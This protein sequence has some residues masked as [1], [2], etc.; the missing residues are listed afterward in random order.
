VSSKRTKLQ[1]RYE[2]RETLGRGGMGI[3][4]KAYD[5]LMNR[6]VA[7]KTILDVDNPETLAMFYKEW[8]TL[9]A[10]VH[11]NVINIYDI[12]EFEDEGAKKPFFVMPLLPG[13]TLDKLIKEAS[14]RLSVA[15]VLAIIDQAAR[16]LHAA[17]EQGLIHRDVKPSNI[18]VM[19]DGSVKIIDFGIVR[20]ASA[21]S[22]TTLK[23]TLY[24]MAPEQLSMKPPSPLSDMFALGAVTYEALTRLRPFRG[25]NDGEVIEAIQKH[26]PPPISELNHEV[27][28]AISQ[29][30]HKAMAKQPWHRFFNMR[31]YGDALMKALR[32]EPLE[33]FDATKIKPRLERAAQSYEQADYEF[34]SEVL[35]ELEAEGHLD[36]GIALLR[37]QVDQAVRQI[38]IK[39]MLENARRF[40]EANEFPLAL[41]KIQ[42][43][44]DLDA[45]DATALSL[46][47]QVERERREK[48]ISEWIT[49]SRQ[50]LENQAFRQA[51]EALENVLQLKPN[52]TDA[53]SLAAEVGRREKEVAAVREQKAKLYQAAMQAWEQGDVT[54]ALTKLESLLVMD[55]DNPEADTGRSHTY[56]GL[57]NKVHSEHNTL[58]NSLEEAHRHLSG[59]NYEAALAIC[60]QYLVKY[61]NHVL[62]QSLKFDVEERQRQGLSRVIAET[63]KRVEEEPDLD[64]RMAI[65]EEVLKVYPGEPHFM[66][67]I[68]LVRDKRDLVNSIVTKARFFEERGQF[69]E[70]LDQWQILKSI[71]EKQ[72]GLAFEIE[73]VIKRRDTQ[74]L[75]NS[76]ARWVEQTD[77][78]L[79]GG[80]YERARKT[81]QNALLE[82]PNEAELLELDK[83]V[84][85]HQERANQATELLGRAR[86]SGDSWTVDQT[87][88]DLREAYKLDPRNSVIRTVL[89]NTLL[90]HARQSM[91]KNPETAETALNEILQLDPG[92]VPARSQLTQLADHKR[93]EFVAWCLTQ[94]RRLQT[95]GDFAGAL[96]VAGQGLASYPNDPRLLQ[97][98]ATLSRVQDAAQKSQ[99]AARTQNP[100]S[101][102][103][104]PAPV[105]P[106]PPT[107][108]P[109]PPQATVPRAASQPVSQPPA[110]LPAA[111][112]VL[113]PPPPSPQLRMPP[114]PPGWK[115][116]A[117]ESDLTSSEVKVLIPTAARSPSPPPNDQKNGKKKT[118]YA[119][120][121]LG[122]GV[123]VLVLSGVAYL[124]RNKSVPPPPPVEVANIKV[125]L[126][127]TPPGAEISVNG[128]ACTSPCEMEL[129]PGDYKAEAK[130]ANFQ[131]ATV[132]FTIA[133][134][135]TSVPDVNL[136]L[137]PPASLVTITTD[138]PDGTVQLDGA[139]VGQI[140]GTDFEIPKLTPAQHVIYL[141]SGAFSSKVTVD[142]AEGA[143]PKVAGMQ[144]NAMHGFVVSHSGSTAQV[145]GSLD[146]A[147][148]S[149]DGKPVG[150]LN[151]GGL[152]LKDLSPGSHEVLVESQAGSAR[153]TF[154]TGAT[155]LT[156]ALMSQ[157]NI[158]VLYIAA[159]QDGVEIYINGEK[160]K[161]TTIAG[162]VR[163]NLPP[164]SYVVRVQKVGFVTPPEQ[165]ANLPKADAVHLEF[166]LI[167]ARA[168]LMIHHGVVG[169]EVFVD[170]TRIGLVDPSGEFSAAYIEPGR[171]TVSLKHDRLQTR[172]SEQVF[173]VGKT[174][175]LEGALQSLMGTLKIE[176]TPSDARVRVRKLGEQQDQD[177]RD[178][179]IS[180]AEGM[181]TVSAS[182]P[183]YQDAQTTVRVPAG[184]F[185]TAQLPLRRVESNAPKV[186]PPPVA[187]DTTRPLFALDEWLKVGWN[188]EGNAMTRI[189][190]DNT[191][192]PVDLSKATVQFTVNLIKGKRVEWMAAYR[193]PKNYELFQF[194]ETY[195]IRT[196]VVNGK[197]GKSERVAH[198]AKIKGY[199]TFSIKIAPQSIVTSIL[200]D[201]QWSSLDDFRP[202]GGVNTGRF[203]FHIPGKDQLT[204]ND[205]KITAN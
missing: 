93:E 105:R 24:Y 153:A 177:V 30:V 179:T 86:Q 45:N 84:S 51:R 160:T 83:L 112:N 2:L 3:V 141:E 35:S 199:N 16:G 32:N 173:A 184:G 22:R 57:Y 17:H 123:V 203:G 196:D 44:L 183:R 78:Y 202:M 76:K 197:H 34:A 195:F 120:I 144:T 106:G 28:F 118:A 4:Y 60:Q 186:T 136:T 98:Q 5:R 97:L 131:T 181:Y 162:K 55:R 77:K 204:L 130:L 117:T 61:P 1:E 127:S 142:I 193:D 194:E 178:L 102:P 99:D 154:D 63:D 69:V 33:Y 121:A 138:L 137:L 92:H 180:L 149:L 129:A 109:V 191:L 96:A 115:G 190:G 171:H 113:P 49:L 56:Q 50:H 155:G 185:A 103:K 101:L 150:V 169:S 174:I 64:R 161:R 80:D 65:L 39:Q 139:Q 104:D 134:G 88:T 187:T 91:E 21:N 205:F 165:T 114:P 152:E 26:S 143:M 79:E 108:P 146:G 188:R 164:K 41:R 36:Q 201:Q 46:K 85:K 125:N 18:F 158:G 59:D 90:E 198:G 132:P 135:Q 25:A 11:P 107:P 89:V 119:G 82:F 163:L 175:E 111:P 116:A 54:Q 110:H 14:P 72:P 70:A 52:D 95:D 122:L 156:A 176:V 58:K 43:A 37:G 75:H 159:N 19:D 7:L 66:R 71:H 140:Q 192:A 13:T 74:A 126:R 147:K 128:K 67:A 170:G 29:V 157:Q 168:A 40:Y 47:S 124:R 166:R 172:Q 182:A 20:S 167:A 10:M 31:E 62:F 87:L 9:S 94:A 27:G 200:R 42:E 48:K 8:S 15:G 38:R 23:G 151:A 133:A 12:G 81:I 6:E 100:A 148:A 68:Q 53:L 73:R 145:Y 189:G